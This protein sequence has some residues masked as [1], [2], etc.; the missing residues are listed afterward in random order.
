MRRFVTLLLLACGAAAAQPRA[1]IELLPQAEVQGEPVRLGEVAHLQSA[2][3]ALMRKLVDLPI[4]RV[5]RT[6]QGASVQRDA[7]AQWLRRQAG[8][9]PEEVEWRGADSARVMRSTRQIH[10]A[11]IAAAAVQAMRE[12]F[13][14]QLDAAAVR[15]WPVPRDI[16]APAGAVWLQVRPLDGVQ[17]RRRTMTWV[18]LWS[19]DTFLRVVPVALEVGADAMPLA[20]GASAPWPAPGASAS[21]HEE[22]LLVGRGEWATL[23]SSAGVVMLESRVEVLQDGRA[24]ERVRVR[25]ST[26]TGIVFARVVGPAQLELAP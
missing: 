10:G 26:A 20:A 2:D 8:L 14:P 25:P 7:L 19:D 3:L 6:G 12:R 1:T 11:E 21:R 5:P 4:G 24:G 17:L 18:E 9:A 13:G 23:R 16:E 22:P 15:A